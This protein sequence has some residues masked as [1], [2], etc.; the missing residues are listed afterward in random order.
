VVRA[1]GRLLLHDRIPFEVVNEAMDM[2]AQAE[3]SRV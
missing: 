2:F 1:N 3:S